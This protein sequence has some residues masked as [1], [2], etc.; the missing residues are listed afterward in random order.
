[1]SHYTTIRASKV[2]YIIH[3]RTLKVGFHYAWFYL[4]HVHFDWQTSVPAVP[5]FFALLSRLRPSSARRGCSTMVGGPGKS[6]RQ[7][8][9]EVIDLPRRV[10]YYWISSKFVGAVLTRLIII[11][12]LK[13]H[14]VYAF[15]YNI[16]H[17]V[18]S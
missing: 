1:M 15:G 12:S 2:E 17:H 16:L 13:N 14:D 3:W 5:A 11:K 9:T 10:I 7:I 4:E 6:C 8:L 18:L